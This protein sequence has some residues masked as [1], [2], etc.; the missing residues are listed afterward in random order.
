MRQDNASRSRVDRSSSLSSRPV[1]CRLKG[2]IARANRTEQKKRSARGHR[3][4]EPRVV[5]LAGRTDRA[6]CVVVGKEV[7]TTS[8]IPSPPTA[9]VLPVRT[10]D[11]CCSGRRW[12]EG[13][14][15][16]DPLESTARRPDAGSDWIGGHGATG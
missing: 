11:R 14:P 15:H 16:A 8:S 2:L 7:H 6:A 10:E 12:G 4:S 1:C 3:T 13:D 5:V 9:A